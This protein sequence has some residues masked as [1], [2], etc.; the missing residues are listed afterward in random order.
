[1]VMNNCQLLVLLQL[2]QRYLDGIGNEK[3]KK[4][5]NKHLE[6]LA[7]RLDPN[8]G[9]LDKL[10]R[11]GCFSNRECQDIRETGSTGSK[12]EKLI[13]MVLKKNKIEEFIQGLRESNQMHLVNYS[14]ADGG[15]CFLHL[16]VLIISSHLIDSEDTCI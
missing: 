5:I 13:E 6:F 4:L 1:M 12:A 8:F 16:A 9:I 3:L 11:I 10:L 2:F 7:D 14:M 15:E